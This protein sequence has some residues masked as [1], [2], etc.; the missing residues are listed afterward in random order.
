VS[1]H[2]LNLQYAAD[3]EVIANWDLP[4]ALPSAVAQLTEF[5]S[6]LTN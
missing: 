6:D 5:P 1:R 3:D 2:Y 4:K